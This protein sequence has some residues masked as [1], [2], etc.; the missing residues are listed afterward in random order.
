MLFFLWKILLIN[1]IFLFY[2]KE[3]TFYDCFIYEIF[4]ILLLLLLTLV[5]C[6]NYVIFVIVIICFVFFSFPLNFY[7]FFFFGCMVLSYYFL[8]LS[9]CNKKAVM[10]FIFHR[11][12]WYIY[13]EFFFLIR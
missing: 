3:M 2:S 1:I 12:I 11:K 10:Y 7:F 4:I 13:V 9:R 6:K 5:Y 8:K